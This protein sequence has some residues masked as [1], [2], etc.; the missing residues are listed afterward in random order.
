M[1]EKIG[2]IVNPISGVKGKGKIP[3][4]IDELLDGNRFEP[5]VFYTERAGH[6]AEIAGQLSADGFRYVVAVG[7]DGTVNEV[8][9]GI[10]HTDTA[11]GI[12]PSGSGNGL[13]RHLGIPVN[14]R[15]AIEYINNACV[16]EVDYGKA[17]GHVFFCTCGAGFDAHISQ[18]FALAGARGIK[19]YVEKI[20]GEYFTYKPEKYRIKND[21]IDIEQ[22]AFLVTFANAS[23]YGNNAYIAPHANMQDGMMDVCVLSK[24]PLVVVPELAV[25]LFAKKIDKSYYMFSLNA[26]RVVLEREKAGPFHFDGEAGEAGSEIEVCIV[27]RGLKV[28]VQQHG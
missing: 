11:L 3:E 6:G 22:E 15:K 27:P 8:G 13:A 16:V 10:V 5:S 24:F 21:F 1:K 12:I 14:V 4:L 18:Q 25:R 17:N 28:L 9:R 26:N 20:I 7:G 2:F 23:Q 19:T